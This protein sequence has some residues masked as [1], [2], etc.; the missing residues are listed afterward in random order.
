MLMQLKMI[1]M[2]GGGNVK[3]SDQ[4]SIY[5]IKEAATYTIFTTKG[6]RYQRSCMNSA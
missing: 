1:H 4:F 3:R 5:L 6:R 2:M